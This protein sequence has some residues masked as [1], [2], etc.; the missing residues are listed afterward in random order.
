MWSTSSS[1]LRDRL[2]SEEELA[3]PS[4]PASTRLHVQHQR[5]SGSN[6][7]TTLWHDSN[8]GAVLLLL[9]CA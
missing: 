8:K 9:N 1:F 3:G 6:E 7:T 2:S 4:Q 5:Y